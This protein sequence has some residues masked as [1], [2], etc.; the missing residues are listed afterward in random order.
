M[1]HWDELKPCPFCADSYID[2]EL[3]EDECHYLCPNCGAIG[4]EIDHVSAKDAWN[5]RDGDE[6]HINP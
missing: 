3:D 4:P 1:A 6:S 2:P 5:M